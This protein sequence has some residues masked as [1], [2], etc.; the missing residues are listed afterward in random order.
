[1]TTKTTTHS[2]QSMIV[3]A[4]WLIKPNEPKRFSSPVTLIFGGGSGVL[5]TLK[6]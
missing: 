3:Q 2:E 1:M 4:L 5:H 6:V